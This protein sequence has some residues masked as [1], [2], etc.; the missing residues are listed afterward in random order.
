[1]KSHVQ[2]ILPVNVRRPLKKFG[3]DLSVARRKRRLSVEMMCERISV[4]KSTWQPM[5]KGD[6]SVCLGAYVQA[7]FAL[8]FGC[9]MGEIADQH[10]DEAGLLLEA[11]RL[12]KRIRQV[13][14]SARK[15]VTS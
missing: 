13:R 10:S 14:G 11:K 2:D 3:M 5:E 12:P 1:M 6:P 8:G 9:P 4:S 15:G 7:L